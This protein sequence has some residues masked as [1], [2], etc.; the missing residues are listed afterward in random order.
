MPPAWDAPE[1][2]AH[3]RALGHVPVIDHKTR[4]GEKSTVEAEARAKRTAGY[5][6]AEDVRYKQ[7]SS[8]ERVNGNL[9]DN[10]GGNHVRV[11]GAAKVFCHL[12]FGI[13]VITVEQL[14]RLV[15]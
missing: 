3:S 6:L 15:Q 5:V 9:K 7:R 1:I 2:A 14:M 12:M 8:A 10:C 13:V 11:R 4:R